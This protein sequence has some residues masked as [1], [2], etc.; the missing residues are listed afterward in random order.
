MKLAL[1][2]A[3]QLADTSVAQNGR[4]DLARGVDTDARLA[5]GPAGEDGR[6]TGRKSARR[7]ERVGRTGT[8]QLRVT[9]RLVARGHGKSLAGGTVGEQGSVDP[10][11]DVALDQ[12]VGAGTDIKGM[13]G[14][15]EPVVVVGVPVAVELELGRATR[16]VVDVVAGEG[17]LVIFAVSETIA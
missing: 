15:V 12:G 14:V 13:A 2:G 3:A 10:V 6:V 16:S 11:K 7:D 5:P 4:L 17:D 8:A 9:G 1:R